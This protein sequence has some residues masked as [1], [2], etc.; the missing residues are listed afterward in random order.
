M[1][2]ALAWKMNEGPLGRVVPM[3]AKKFRQLKAKAPYVKV[4]RVSS[5]PESVEAKGP[6]LRLQYGWFR[7]KVLKRQTLIQVCFGKR[8]SSAARA[9]K[10][11]QQDSHFSPTRAKHL[12]TDLSSSSSSSPFTFQAGVLRK[13]GIAARI[14][15]LRLEALNVKSHKPGEYS[16]FVLRSSGTVVGTAKAYSGWDII[17]EAIGLFI[18]LVISHRR[19]EEALMEKLL[20]TVRLFALWDFQNPRERSWLF[21]MPG[22]AL[23]YRQMRDLKG[24]MGAARAGRMHLMQLRTKLT[25]IHIGSSEKGRSRSLEFIGTSLVKQEMKISP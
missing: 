9:K 5:I 19:N 16:L 11:K 7:A 6:R 10:G 20:E 8:D 13:E 15:A 18:L 21:L 4:D 3:R 1:R 14:K 23:P 12:F 25:L 24:Q 17:K 2:I 22:R